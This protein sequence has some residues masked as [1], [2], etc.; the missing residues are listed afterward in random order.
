MVTRSVPFSQVAKEMLLNNEGFIPHLVD[1]LL[2][3]PEH[4]RK[5]II[6]GIKTVVQRDFAEAIAQLALYLPGREALRRDPAVAE[7][8]QQ[9]ILTGWT[10]EARIS[11]QAALLAMSSEEQEPHKVRALSPRCS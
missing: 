8:L 9:V 2:L 1:A 11:S 10:E 6:E 5:D 3:D 7:A 4:P